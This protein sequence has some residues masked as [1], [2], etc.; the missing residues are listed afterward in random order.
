MRTDDVHEEWDE[1][2]T[3]G[4]ACWYATSADITDDSPTS[5]RDGYGYGYGDGHG[6]GD[7]HGP[8]H[9]YDGY[10]CI[11]LRATWYALDWTFTQG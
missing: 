6:D 3:N 7:G 2:T 11:W 9:E 4:N 10:G 1:S 5:P 8:R